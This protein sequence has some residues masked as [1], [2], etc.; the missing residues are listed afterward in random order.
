M[1][2]VFFEGRGPRPEPKAATHE[3]DGQPN[4]QNLGSTKNG[5][6]G[7][8]TSTPWSKHRPRSPTS[9]VV[10]TSRVL[11]YP[12]QEYVSSHEQRTAEDKS[13]SRRATLL[14]EP[15]RRPMLTIRSRRQVQ[16]TERL[17]SL[18]GNG[19]TPSA[20]S[21]DPLCAQGGIDIRLASKKARR[22]GHDKQCR[23]SSPPER[24]N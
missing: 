9:I 13:A 6:C 23:M 11:D 2:S 16:R 19:A 1:P 10:P 8:Q 21:K 22:T 7:S 20:A 5:T 12:T 4:R 18:A 14:S 17:K 24:N 3:V 15:S